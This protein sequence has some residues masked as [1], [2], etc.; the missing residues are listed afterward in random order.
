M[1]DQ[2]EQET[3]DD[4]SPTPEDLAHVP[5]Y[6]LPDDGMQ[7]YWDELRTQTDR[8]AAVLAA[9]HLEWRVRESIKV[10]FDIWDDRV[11][12]VFGKG[13]K[14][15]DLEFSAQCRVAYGLALIGPIAF[16]DL[17]LIGEIRN[18]FAHNPSVRNFDHK[19]VSSKVDELQTTEVK[20]QRIEATTRD[21]PE[22]GK[23]H[24]PKKRRKKYI[25]TSHDLS[26]GLW[27]ASRHYALIRKNYNFPHVG[28]FPYDYW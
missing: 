8:G 12:K 17:R 21:I 15:G 27:L 9:S 28:N 26:I 13:A 4:G 24:R 18:V 25:A 11:K 22:L 14:G 23:V 16:A 20:A 6:G 5:P 2:L 10:R 3:D 19:L 7:D 1:D